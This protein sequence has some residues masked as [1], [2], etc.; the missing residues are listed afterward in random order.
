[1]SALQLAHESP[2][3]ASVIVGVAGGTCA[4]TRS[5][6]LGPCRAGAIWM[7]LPRAPDAAVAAPSRA[8][9]EVTSARPC[10]ACIAGSVLA[11]PIGLNEN[12]GASGR[13][14][15]GAW[16]APVA[17]PDARA[18]FA[19]ASSVCEGADRAGSDT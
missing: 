7:A 2:S 3:S 17:R 16:R 8:G 9:R 15:P 18:S 13:S 4:S 5:V 1:M 6:T 19:G 10:T 14:R 12:T 11:E